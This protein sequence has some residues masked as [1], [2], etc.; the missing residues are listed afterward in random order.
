M[1]RYGLIGLSML[2][3]AATADAAVE[4]IEVM[5]RQVLANGQPFGAAGQ[6]EKLRGKVWYA[7]DPRSPANQLVPDLGLAPRDERGRV[8]FAADFVMMRPVDA[9]KGNG[10]LLYDVSNRGGLTM[11]TQLNEAAANNDPSTAAELGNAFLLQQGF[12]MLWSAWVWDVAADPKDRRLILDPPIAT[13]DGK[14]GGKPITGKV[15]YEIIVDKITETTGFAGNLGLAYAPAQADAPDGVLTVRDSLEGKRE[16]IPRA[17][18]RFV[19]STDERPP[20][21]LAL[22]GGFQTGKI[23][24]LVYSARD[25]VVVAAGLAA[26]RD[27]LSRLRTQP[28]EGAP[29]PSRT[30]IFGISQSGRV[31]QTMLLRGMHVDEAGKPVFDGAYIHVAGGGKGAFDHRFAMPTRHF[32]MLEDHAYATDYFPFT[33][34]VE[35]DPVTGVHASVLDAARVLKSVPKLVY[36]NTSAE[37]WNRAA[38]LIHTDPAGKHD[39]G[40]DPDARIYLIAGAQ[41]YAGRAR[42]RGIY[43]NCVNPMNHYREMRAILLALDRWVRD[44]TQPPPSVYPRIEDG[45]L[46]TVAAYKTEFPKL[47]EL[48]LPDGNLRPP[49]LDFGQRF[50]RQRVADTVPPRRTGYFEALVPKPDADGLDQGGIMTPE[51][52]VPLGTRVGFNT[53]APAAGFPGAT[54]RWDG[55]F[56]PFA[57]SEAERR[58]RND[59]RPSLE[60]RYTDRADYE[61]KLRAAAEKTV[62]AGF[63]RTEE[64]DAVVKQGG[65]FYE[66]IMAR[67]PADKTCDY[68]YDQ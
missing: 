45:T 39:A 51:L 8:T 12:T 36:V 65:A 32:S 26:I 20:R 18:W 6:Y 43:A 66:R 4:R 2:L 68:L 27:L 52:Q 46:V 25:P 3:A 49:R 21:Q 48:T 23:Y 17:D 31:I 11:L 42:T 22:T 16:V 57:R 47:R 44:G 62:A 58:F 56:I 63:L 24:E 50:A 28:F 34:R 37:Y 38:S 59:P 61:K 10:A 54:A 7:L 67:E 33:T 53:R 40:V 41:H 5:D 1:M 15:A 64:V 29:A 35:Q 60:Q 14:A 13:Q 55:S 19:P 9:A 30:L